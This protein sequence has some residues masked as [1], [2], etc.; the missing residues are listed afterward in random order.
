MNKLK[1]GIILEN[2]IVIMPG[3]NENRDNRT[4]LKDLGI[5]DAVQ[6]KPIELV[7]AALIPENDEWWVSPKAHPEKWEFVVDQDITPEWLDKEKVEKSFR[8]AV[9]GWWKVHVIVEQEIDELNSGYYCLKCC[10]PT[11]RLNHRA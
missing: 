8:E 3:E 11:R 7:E 5:Q 6:G 2:G 10:Q 1:R 4:L 9:Y